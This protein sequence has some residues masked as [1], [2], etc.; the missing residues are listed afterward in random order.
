MSYTIFI[1]QHQKFL[2]LLQELTYLTWFLFSLMILMILNV[3]SL[4]STSLMDFMRMLKQLI[5]VL[6][7]L[8][9]VQN[10]MIK[11]MVA[12]YG[13]NMQKINSLT[14]KFLTGQYKLWIL[15]H[16]AITIVEAITELKLT[17]QRLQL[18]PLKSVQSLKLILRNYHL[19]FVRIL[20][21]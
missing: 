15:W 20:W 10:S 3:T 14:R 13:E 16:N 8:W 21:N 9:S 4:L 19:L 12:I 2:E 6:K 11:K 17:I 7:M 5:C 1:Q 18:W